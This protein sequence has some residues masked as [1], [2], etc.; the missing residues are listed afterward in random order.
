[1]TTSTL[2]DTT[3]ATYRYTA[4]AL[5][6]AGAK[7]DRVEHGV[8]Q[9][10]SV[11]QH[12]QTVLHGQA[13]AIELALDQAITVHG[14]HSQEAIRLKTQ[15]LGYNTAITGV[16]ETEAALRLFANLNP[17]WDLDWQ[18]SSALHGNTIPLN[19]AVRL[20]RESAPDLARQLEQINE[21]V[22]VLREYN[23]IRR[24]VR[25]SN[26]LD[27]AALAER[28]AF[29]EQTALRVTASHAAL[30]LAPSGGAT[31]ITA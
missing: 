21:A 25:E 3:L 6:H 8:P 18:S 28:N 13:A 16:Q 26:P 1:M 15:L 29:L 31:A 17:E 2:I 22:A 23:G 11:L 24:D 12:A 9:D 20:L 14:Q 27:E 7:L 19:G 10:E 5:L 4:G 30:A